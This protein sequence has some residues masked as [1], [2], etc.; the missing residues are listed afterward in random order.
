M[1]ERRK[2][3][4]V[5]VV[6]QDRDLTFDLDG[7]NRI[8]KAAERRA[9]SVAELRDAGIG[10]RRVFLYMTV[11]EPAAMSSNGCSR[12]FPAVSNSMSL[13]RRHLIRHWQTVTTRRIKIDSGR[14]SSV[15][16]LGCLLKQT[17]NGPEIV[18]LSREG[19]YDAIV[20]PALSASATPFGTAV[21]DWPIYVL[22]HA[23]C[24]VF[25][26]VHPAIPRE[27]VG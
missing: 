24:S 14:S 18:R 13:E 6:S 7:G 16:Q 4:T 23:P 15:V 26:A 27:A 17:Q 2:P 8:P 22:Q 9:R 10:I 19:V 12:W 1:E 25:I 21:D 3:L 11:R 20:L 5:H